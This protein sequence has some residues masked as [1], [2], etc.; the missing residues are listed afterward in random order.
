M[1][2]E[3]DSKNRDSQVWIP[4]VI[5][6][7]ITHQGKRL[8][9]RKDYVDCGL[10]EL[11]CREVVDHPGAV[12][13]LPLLP[14]GKVLMIEQYRHALGTLSLEFPAGTL[15]KG[16]DPT[17]CAHRELHEE[18]NMK[19]GRIDSLGKIHPAPGF[20]NEVE[21][22]YIAQDLVFDK[23]TPDP[24]EV[25]VTKEIEVS[26]V[27]EMIKD[28]EITDAKSISIFFR[29]HLRKYFGNTSEIL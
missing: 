16:E 25:I 11:V 1:S 18:A 15:E 9:V 29:A 20:C 13:I 2:K 4:P 7:E 17:C 26:R 5:K 6:S 22:L 21:Y 28:G 27:F 23:G 14:E 19:A 24:G 12:V 3:S 10:D 8:T